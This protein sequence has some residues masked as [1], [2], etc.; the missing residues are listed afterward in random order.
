MGIILIPSQQEPSQTSSQSLIK[1]GSVKQ[2]R[3][4]F[5][6]PDVFDFNSQKSQPTVRNFWSS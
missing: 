6:P 1:G 3:G 4:N 5:H 2:D